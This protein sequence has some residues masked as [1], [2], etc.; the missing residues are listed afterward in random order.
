[1]TYI[2]RFWKQKKECRTSNSLLVQNMA[3]KVFTFYI[4]HPK[5]TGLNKKWKKNGYIPFTIPS[6]QL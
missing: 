1:M 3:E 6:N 2:L 4:P 5:Q